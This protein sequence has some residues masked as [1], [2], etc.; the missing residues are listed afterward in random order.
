MT[1]SELPRSPFAG[2][3]GLSDKRERRVLTRG[4]IERILAAHHLYLESERRQGQRADLVAVDLSQMSFAG[5]DLRRA[6]L[7]QANLDSV[8]LTGAALE[9]TN[10]VGAVLQRARLHHA[11]LTKARLSGANLVAADLSQACL[12]R[13]DLE[14]ALMAKA[15]LMIWSKRSFLAR[16]TQTVFPRFFPWIWYTPSN[17]GSR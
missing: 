17:H 13:A 11:D 12:A 10:L 14:F 6:K 4:E 8:D 3:A 15:V 2:L 16:G 5:C 9:R 1:G 7:A